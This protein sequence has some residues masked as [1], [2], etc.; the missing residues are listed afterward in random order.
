MANTSVVDLNANL[1]CFGRCYLD[2]LNGQVLA[3]LPGHCRLLP[4][5]F[6]VFLRYPYVPGIAICRVWSLYIAL[7]I[8]TASPAMDS[9]AL[10]GE[11]QR[12]KREH[13]RS[14]LQP[15]LFS[16]VPCK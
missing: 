9:T 12:W 10:A 16:D 7:R 1:V 15:R 6:T 14:L 4:V 2:I 11:A 8:R 3:S 13:E 5:S